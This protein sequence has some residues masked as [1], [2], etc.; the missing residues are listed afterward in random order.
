MP[1]RDLFS[2]AQRLELVAIPEDEGE[3]IRLYTLAP[4][5]LAIIRQRRGDANRL[6]FAAQLCSIRYPGLVIGQDDSPDQRMLVMVSRQLMIDPGLWTKYAGRDQ[7]RREH[8][9]EIIG[10]YGLT[11]ADSKIKAL[12]TGSH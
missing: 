5:D 6:G 12:E 11:F 10:I 9:Q 3:L 1:R 7:T 8:L 2:P 4:Q